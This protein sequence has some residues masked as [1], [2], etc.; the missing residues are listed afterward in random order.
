MLGCDPGMVRVV[1]ES[2]AP[3]LTPGE[4]AVVRPLNDPAREIRRGMVVV[5]EH[6]SGMP[7]GEPGDLFLFR[8]VALAGDRITLAGEALTVNGAAVSEPYAVYELPPAVDPGAPPPQS[9]VRGVVV[10]SGTVY[11][12]GDNRY[13]AIDSRYHGPVPVESVRGYVPDP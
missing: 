10:P 6:F 7:M 9:D 8:A 5:Y 2:M 12:L 1:S 11:V 13:N 3:T 4:F